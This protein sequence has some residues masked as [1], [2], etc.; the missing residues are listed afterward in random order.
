[1]IRKLVARRIHRKNLRLML[2][3]GT[4]M[5]DEDAVRT[6]VSQLVQDRDSEPRGCIRKVF[7]CTVLPILH[8]FNMLLPAETLV[9]RVFTLTEEIKQLQTEKYDVAEDENTL[10]PA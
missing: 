6:A 8:L 1:M 5:N 3:K 7:D 10:S 9:D 4:D 2:P